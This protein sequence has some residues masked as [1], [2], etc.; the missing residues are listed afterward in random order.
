VDLQSHCGSDV[1]APLLG[2]RAPAAAMDVHPCQRAGSRIEAGCED[3]DVELVLRAVVQP[4]AVR[5]DALDRVV[6]SRP[7]SAHRRARWRRYADCG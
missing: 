6:L 3:Q 4:Q 2:Q 7:G 1:A 5:R